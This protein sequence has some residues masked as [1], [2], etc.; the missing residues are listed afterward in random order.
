[1]HRINHAWLGTLAGLSLLVGQTQAQSTSYADMRTWQLQGANGGNWVDPQDTTSSFADADSG[2]SVFQTVNNQAGTMFLVS[3][4]ANVINRAVWGTLKIESRHTDANGVCTPS[5]SSSETDDDWLGFV[6]GYRNVDSNTQFP[7][8]YLGFTWNRGGTAPYSLSAGGSNRGLF[9]V[10]AAPPDANGSPTGSGVTIVDYD[11]GSSQGWAYDTEYQFRILYTTDLIRVYINDVLRLEATAAQAG[12]DAFTAGQFGFTNASQANVLFGDVREADASSLDTAPVASD[13]LFY[14]G[15][16]W[17]AAYDNTNVFDTSTDSRASSI[18]DNDYDPDGDAFTLQVG[19]V[20]LPDA[21]DSTTITGTQGGSFLVYGNGHFVYTAVSDYQTR[22][23][24]Q[25]TFDYTLVDE[26]GTHTATV[27][28]TVQESN[29]TPDDITLTD[30][31]T[32]ST[33]DIRIDQGAAA[34]TEIATIATVENSSGELD[35]YDYELQDASNGAFAIIDDKLVVRDTSVLD[36]SATHTIVIRST[37]VEG[38]SITQTFTIHVDPNAAPT[39][40]NATAAAVANAPLVFGLADFP[41]AD[42]DGDTFASL[43]VTTLPT[44]GTL[45]LDLNADGVADTNEVLQINFN[46]VVTRAQLTG[47]VLKYLSTTSSDVTDTFDFKVGDGAAYATSASTMTISVSADPCVSN[48]NSAGCLA[49]DSDGDGVTNAQEDA[50][51]TS[52]DSADTDGDGVNDGAEVGGNVNAP[53]DSDGDG[54]IDALE[55]SIVDTDNDGVAAQT[56]PSNSGPCLP[57]GNSTPCLA[58]DTD[59]DGLTNGEEDTLHTDRND[60]DSDGDGI[61]DGV[62][63]G[64]NPAQ[65]VDTDGDG[66]SDVLEHSSVDTDGDGVADSVDLDSDNDGI[67]DSVEA[68][69]GVPRDSDGDGISDHL[70]RD[71]DG[72]GIP[73]AFEAGQDGD[74]P[75]DTDSDGIPDYLDQDSDNDGIP[76]QLEANS[77]G[78]DTD[79]DGIDDAYDADSRNE[80]DMNGDGIGDSATL[81][82]LDHDGLPDHL[83]TDADGD[84]ILDS[85]EAGLTGNDTDGD[86]IDD[87]MDPQFTGGT[88]SDGDGIDDAYVLPDSDGDGVADLLDLDS[89]NDGIFDVVEAGL[90]DLDQDAHADTGQTP[91]S[92]PPD[93]DSDGIADYL[94]LDSNNDGTFDIVDSGF[95]SFDTDNDGR[96]DAGTDS[97]GDGIPDSADPAPFVPGAYADADGDGIPD[98][99]DLDLDND[100]IPDTSEG[101]GDADGDG[102]PNLGDLDSDNDGIPDL[103]EAG[104]VDVDGNGVVDTLTDVDG[105]GLADIYDTAAG[106]TALPTPD[107]DG[108]GVPDYLDIDSDA[109]SLSDVYE[110]GGVDV[111]NDGRLDSI[112]DEN[113]DGLADSVD[114]SLG[115]TP[116]QRSDTDGDGKA[117]NVDTDSDGDGTS[118]S[119]EGRTDSDGDGTPDYLDS[120][121]TLRTAVSGTGSFTWM[122]LVALLGVLGL[123]RRAHIAPLALALVCVAGLNSPRTFASE[124]TDDKG[125]YVGADYGLSWLE[126]ESNGGG[127]V[128]DDDRSDGFRLLAGYAWSSRW[129]AELFY[130]DAGEAGIG[131][132]NPAVGH[133]GELEYEIYGAGIEWSP[134]GSDGRFYPVLKAG[135]VSI[136]NE[137]TDARIDFDRK[138]SLSIYFGAGGALRINPQ[139]AVQLEW[140][141][142]DR[143]SSFL[144]LGARKRW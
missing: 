8:E 1:M 92:A 128:I 68:P 20:N 37:D 81:R 119:A 109:D 74:T 80:S 61:T 18:L 57:N 99:N 52:R 35:A 131:S 107:T 125:F 126:P 104:G 34:Y 54:I 4:D 88:D 76:D 33:T 22:G 139:W 144:S 9:M 50:L 78:Q 45:F 137:V 116:L 53:L 101:S 105:N 98:V 77:S 32:S 96:I 2:R 136:G 65:P 111:N 11:T 133:L 15:L 134:L 127:Y 102:L 26:D 24:Y 106:G 75:L 140:I 46:D 90:I 84:G 71:S 56:D 112:E 51:G 47:G 83:D 141:S 31:D 135:G 43:R 86:G 117:D 87:A 42:T 39:S 89:D 95:A 103:V 44:E 118:D 49:H 16:T 12:V 60:A 29:T 6:V 79:G 120:P 28:V 27:T 5:C 13:D 66:I 38:Q 55:S 130:M 143:D 48:A 115:G 94:D 108:D 25:D 100:G 14:Y 40:G 121:G 129:S 82:D 123:R 85:V 138:N 67:P 7:E 10:R 64:G 122:W 132:D 114:Q 19:G 3:N 30:L 63:V 91:V 124:M 59:G 36:G 70:D 142:Y 73:D 97:D 17:G 113:G 62:E 69:N 41:F 72:D 93:S 23:P 110:A 58:T 21:G